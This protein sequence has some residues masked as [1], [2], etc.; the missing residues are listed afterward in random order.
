M[1]IGNGLMSTFLWQ[2]IEKQNLTDVSCRRKDV[3]DNKLKNVVGSPERV[4]HIL[5]SIF[6]PKQSLGTKI[7]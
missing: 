1:V 2:A 5:T 4:S 6:K 7:E 3:A